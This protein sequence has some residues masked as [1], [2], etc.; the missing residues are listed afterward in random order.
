MTS[1]IANLE[2]GLFFGSWHTTKHKCLENHKI[3]HVFYTNI[4]PTPFLNGVV[5]HYINLDDNSQSAK[6]LFHT[7]LPNI[8]PQI[9]T[10]LEEKHQVLVCCSAG[11][12]RSATIVIAYLMNYRG[13][14]FD[15]AMEFVK[16]RRHI[17][18]NPGFLNYLES[19]KKNNL[20]K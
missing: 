16:R 8:L 14:S 13:M 15:Q 11:K 6:K 9:H 2:N 3:T 12:S 7:I 10:L 20:I 18:I 1:Q 19:K 17:N 5:Y 4:D